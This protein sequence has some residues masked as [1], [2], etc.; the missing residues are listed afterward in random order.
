MLWKNLESEGKVS[1]SSRDRYIRGR[2]FLFGDF[3][4]EM[5]LQLSFEINWP[6]KLRGEV[7]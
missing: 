3:P 4:E 7:A 1:S 5:T 2:R 6:D